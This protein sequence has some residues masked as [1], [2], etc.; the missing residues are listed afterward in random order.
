MNDQGFLEGRVFMDGSPTRSVRREW[1]MEDEKVL[2]ANWPTD[3]V[4]ALAQT[5]DR[6]VVAVRERVRLLGL[7]LPHWRKRRINGYY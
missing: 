6:S 7:T 2:R 1:T 3:D 4:P 5:L